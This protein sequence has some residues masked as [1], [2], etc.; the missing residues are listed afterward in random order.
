MPELPDI[1]LYR[2]QL[3]E[4]ARGRT[5]QSVAIRDARVVQQS[6]DEL[7][8][9]LRGRRIEG[10]RRHGKN[11]FVLLND[12]HALLMHFGMTGTLG[13]AGEDT[14]LEDD[15]A[16]VFDLDDG[17]RMTYR[18]RRKLGKVLWVAEPDDYLAA[19]H[20]GPDALELRE[21]EIV[22][23]LGDGGGL[24]AALMDQG[25]LAGLGNVYTDEAL[26]QAGL[27]PRRMLRSL[28]DEYRLALAKT[29]RQVLE[30]A[31]EHD[32]DRRRLPPDWLTPH[33]RKGA[34]C[35]R[36]GTPLETGQVGGR[37]TFWCPRE[38]PSP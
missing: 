21:R 10:G 23:R 31:I 35:P 2:R 13:Y 29:I 37:T 36:C 18:S 28:D 27:H 8:K 14:P 9:H 22:Q 25:R 17:Q 16:V 3:D 30:V 11:L 15:D 5:L 19:Q 33:R 32:G 1:E 26:F 6:A 34:K 38:Q 4:H 12:G 20:I 7:A 24:K